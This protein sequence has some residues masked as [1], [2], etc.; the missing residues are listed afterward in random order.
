MLDVQLKKA[1]VYT[2]QDNVFI[3]EYKDHVMI[4]PSDVQD[5]IDTYDNYHDGKNLKV[6]LVFPKN[7][8]VSSGARQLAE[9]REK[10]ALAEALVIESTMQRILFKFY[11]RSRK[12]SYP[13]KEFANREDALRWLHNR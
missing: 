10:P 12:V 11:K 7:T 13:I 3:C 6:M 8:D 4:N 5:V 9:Q 2:D 1:H